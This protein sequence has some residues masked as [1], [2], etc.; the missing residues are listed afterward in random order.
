MKVL[1]VLEA[2]SGGTRRHILDLLP[3]LQVRGVWCDLVASPL[4]TSAFG[5]DAGWLRARGVRVFEVP[6]ARGFS[7]AGDATALRQLATHLR[8]QRYD[9]IHC[10]STKA[11]LLGRLARLSVSRR[12]PLVYTPHC[13]AFDTGLP[14]RQRRA[15]RW[16]EAL[17]APLTSHF[18]AVSQHENRTLRRAGLCATDRVSTIHNGV[19]IEGF[20]ALPSLERAALGLHD[21]DFVIGCFGRLTRQKNQGALLRAL[22]QVLE[23]V[24]RARLLLV[25]SGEDE[26]T[27]RALAQQLGVAECITWTGEVS[28]ARP[29]YALCD[30][31][32]QPS[33]WEGFPYTILEAMAARRVVVARDVGGVGEILNDVSG[34]AYKPHRHAEIQQLGQAITE[35]AHDTDWR[36]SAETNARQR[37]EENFTLNRMVQQTIGVY[38]RSAA[39]VL[40]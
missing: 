36:H 24:P 1:H 4:R 5:S 28:E 2:T 34:V 14:H 40:H 17:L 6:M 39:S 12:T 15:A 10:H 29:L 7:P 8:Q 37:V 22:P 32:A 27:L 11:G 38:E 25:G 3:A 20:D 16:M 9:V 19:D 18:I 33:R 23:A 31:V 13:I 30:V 35:A 26:T 21:S